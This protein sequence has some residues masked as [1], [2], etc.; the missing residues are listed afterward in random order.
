MKTTEETLYEAI[1]EAEFIERECG[2]NT[3]SLGDALAEVHE[4]IERGSDQEVRIALTKAMAELS[5]IYAR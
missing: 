5:L 1:T 2:K 4:A 3:E